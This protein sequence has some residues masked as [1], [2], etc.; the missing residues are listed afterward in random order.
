M[1]RVLYIFLLVFALGHLC[2]FGLPWWSIV[3]VGALA[4]WLLPAPAMRSFIAAFAGGLSLWLLNAYLLDSA[5]SGVLSTRVGQLFLGLKG[6]H[7]LLI[8]G[9][10]GGL[11]SGL[12]ALTGLFARDVYVCGKSKP[13]SEDVFSK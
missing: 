2:R 9:I 3:P 8:T 7:L 1:R 4:G 10:L 13:R 5:N 11:L 12:G 6:W